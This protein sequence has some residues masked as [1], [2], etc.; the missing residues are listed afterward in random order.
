VSLLEERTELS[1]A[2]VRSMCTHMLELQAAFFMF[3]D[4]ERLEPRNNAA[5]RAIRFAV[6]RPATDISVKVLFEAMQGF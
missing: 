3:S 6:E 1:N 2:K 4:V 5:D